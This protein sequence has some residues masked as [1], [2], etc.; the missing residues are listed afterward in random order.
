EAETA[1]PWSKLRAIGRRYYMAY[2]R[3]Q[4]N[5]F[6]VETLEQIAALAADYLEALGYPAMRP[7]SIP[8]DDGTE[9]PVALEIAQK[10]GAPLLWV[11]LSASTDFSAGVIESHVFPA[12]LGSFSFTSQTN[13]ELANKILYDQQEPPRW[14]LF[15]GM[16]QIVLL[17][18]N[19]WNAKRCL[20]FDLKEL[21]SRND[22]STW[23]AVAVLLHHDSLCPAE[24]K[25]LL[26]ALDEESE[27]N[28]AGVPDDL[29]YALRESI[30]LLGNEVLYDL[31][32]NKKRDLDANPVDAGELT[33]QC[34]R[35]MYRML[36]VLFMES[37]ED[38]GYAPMKAGA[39]VTG[40]SLESLRQIAEQM[41]VQP[42]EKVLEG[43]FV[44][45]TLKTLFDLI[46]TGYPKTDEGQQKYLDIKSHTDDFLLPPLKAH[47]FDPERTKLVHEAKLR[48]R[49]MLR[50]IDLMSLTR[51]KDKKNA[52]RGRISYANLGIN[53]MGAVYEALLSYRGFI[54]EDKLYE[55]KRAKD[56]F[57]ELDVGY[58]VKE[59]ELDQYTEN[60][61]ARYESGD[62]KGKL[63]EYEKGTFIYRLAGREREKSA[64]YYTPE[65]LTKCLVKYALKELL[66]DKT[67]DD[68]LQITVCEPA[69]GSAAF[70]NE[71]INQLAEAYL[72]KRQEERG[73]S[74]PY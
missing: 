10:S 2:D 40:Y 61:R 8:L 5:R 63:R 52:R 44:G 51:E 66:K 47:I 54:A 32:E 69:M 48:N 15:I 73:E 56:K 55:V 25:T 16:N 36:F 50:I 43:T 64:S 13:E 6:D 49:V 33:L 28:A 21:F 41:S 4:R 29:K 31:K 70:L 9:V 24:G 72:K 7:E 12:D 71:A 3:F 20:S 62:K 27:K 26:D 60:E 14:L 37:R 39:Y 11:L 18:R 35:Y 57:N 19:K 1:A 68:I 23:Q 38:L 22:E 74:I 67:A 45:D 53:Q 30:E 17:D 42:D 65:V 58:F 59:N 34:L 46:Y